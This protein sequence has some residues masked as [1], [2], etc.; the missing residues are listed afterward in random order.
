MA[1]WFLFICSFIYL[2]VHTRV[3]IH[4]YMCIHSG[5]D[6]IISTFV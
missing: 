1:F 2:C 6:H 4:V 3:H 5:D